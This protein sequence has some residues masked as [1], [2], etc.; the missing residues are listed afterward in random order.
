MRILMIGDIVGRAGRKALRIFLPQ[1]KEQL[2][3]HLI[4]ANGEN[5]AGGFGI[6]ESVKD[7]IL[8]LGV[9]VITLGNHAWDNKDIYNFL[10]E[11]E[12]LIRPANYPPH[13]PGRGSM[14][15][16]CQGKRILII[17]LLGRVF[18]EA[19]DCPFR[20]LDEILAAYGD[21]VADYILVDFHGEATSEKKAMG[22]YA[23][24][25]VSVV[26]GTH[27]HIQTA[28]EQILPGN[29]GYITDVGMT[30]AF[31]SILGMKRE[32]V[33]E[34]LRTQRPHRFTVAKGQ[35][36]LNGLFITLAEGGAEGSSVKRINLV[37]EE[38]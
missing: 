8:S 16:Y 24:G 13:T 15:L 5:A 18:M 27:T 2:R 25:R 30:G 7:E 4:L 3:P 6:T 14:E 22:Y 37:T 31:H 10:E 17:N 32:D 33:L 38:P 20:C 1:V 9:D 28:D 34:R 11:E 23:A 36:Q 35:V 26:V 19:V 21:Q 12:R 29:T